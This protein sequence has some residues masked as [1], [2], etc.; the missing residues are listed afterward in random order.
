M[1]STDE[2]IEQLVALTHGTSDART[3]HLYRQ[4][5][6]VLVELAKAEQRAEACE[7]LPGYSRGAVGT[8][9]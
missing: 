4:S 2:V 5:L 6:Q 7:A 1:V 3:Q 9:H 8:I